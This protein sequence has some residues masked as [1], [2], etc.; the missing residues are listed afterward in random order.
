MNYK[1]QLKFTFLISLKLLKKRF[2]K[3][4]LNITPVLRYGIVHFSVIHLI[5]F[6]GLNFGKRRLRQKTPQVTH[7]SG[8]RSSIWQK[9][10][11]MLYISG[12]N[13]YFLFLESES[14]ITFFTNYFFFNFVQYYHKFGLKI[15]TWGKYFLILS[16]QTKYIL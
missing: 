3:C 12:K 9:K 14:N 7:D 11:L 8:W 4:K 15:F 5:Y 16:N 10:G 1:Y 13:L 2:L 6:L